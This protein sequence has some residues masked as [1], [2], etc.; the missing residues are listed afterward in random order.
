[1][2][3]AL[4]SVVLLGLAPAPAETAVFQSGTEGYHTFRIPAIIKARDGALLAFAEARKAS[5]SD[6]GDIDLVVKR[7]VNGGKTWGKLQVVGDNGPN[8]FG[9]PAPVVDRRT[10]RIVLLST[11]NAGHVHES[12]IRKGTVKPEESRR[13]FVQHSDDNGR[14]WSK[15]RD[16]TPQTKQTDWRWY[17]TGPGH[18][19]SLRSGRLVVP[20]NHSSA[21]PSGSSDLGTEPK[22]YDAH[23]LYSDDGGRNW[24]IGAKDINHDGV[25]NGNES[26]A[27]ELP[28]GR[29]YVNTRDQ[30]GTSDGSRAVAY[31]NDGGRSFTAPFTPAPAL[32]APVVQGSVLQ[33]RKGP[34]L[35]S[36]P[37][38]PTAREKMTVRAS[39]DGGKTWPKSVEISP[40]KAAYSDL[41]Q[42]DEDRVGLLYE[43]GPYERIIFH[44]IG[45]GSLG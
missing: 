44:T 15:A 12:E 35:F 31:S 38:N 19:I 3:L 25:V 37:G 33:V 22:Y 6:T 32:V 13:V 41:V 8:T 24:H 7:S 14:T 16:I 4:I 11:H 18:A 43:A 26:T 45:M 39:T 17:A 9:N 23:L 40:D 42:V 28:D 34:L 10:G 1:M 30:H 2:K 5:A 36:A 27:A 20:A 29:V 21:P